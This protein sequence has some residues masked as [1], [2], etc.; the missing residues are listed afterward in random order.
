MPEMLTHERDF[1]SL[2]ATLHNDSVTGGLLLYEEF[3]D[4]KSTPDDFRHALCI[5]RFSEYL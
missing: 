5:R 2:F 3:I 4:G 1:D